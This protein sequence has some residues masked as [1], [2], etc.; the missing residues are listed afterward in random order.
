MELLGP[1][2][3]GDQAKVSFLPDFAFGM[4]DFFANYRRLRGKPG[5]TTIG[6]AFR[7]WNQRQRRDGD[8]SRHVEIMAKALAQI[9]RQE[10]RRVVLIPFSGISGS[11]LDN[12][13]YWCKRLR[14]R[15]LDLNP[16]AKLSFWKAM[17]SSD[18]TEWANALAE[19]DLQIS[20]RMHSAIL[21]AM[22]GIPSVLVEYEG[23]KSKGVAAYLGLSDYYVPSL[24]S[25]RI[26]DSTE[27]LISSCFEASRIV[28][29]K[30]EEAYRNLTVGFDSTWANINS[31]SD[32]DK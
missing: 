5:D 24:D 16:S 19:V 14:E 23:H 21:G 27:R 6:V 20:V 7:N 2:Y 29:E 11:L 1:A 8:N 25:Q 13:L 32:Y 9:L 12:D 10:T 15:T 26:V 18:P 31:H 30:S 4:W 28:C 17:E 22:L 3:I